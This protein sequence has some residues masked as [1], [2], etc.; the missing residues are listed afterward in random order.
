MSDAEDGGTEAEHAMGR[1]GQSEGR[2]S[3]IP[4]YSREDIR[5]QYCI[6]DKEL[7]VRAIT[8]CLYFCFYHKILE[9]SVHSGVTF[10]QVLT[11]TIL[12]NLFIPG[13]SWT[14]RGGGGCWA[15][16]QITPRDCHP[17]QSMARG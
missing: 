6:N 14:A 10:G 3:A 2:K 1:R 13:R 12:P 4:V 15:A 8:V 9:R 17:A 7:Q 16:S 5:E 11:K